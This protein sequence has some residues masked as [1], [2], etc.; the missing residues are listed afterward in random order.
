MNPLAGL[1]RCL[2]VR[3]VAAYTWIPAFA[4]RDNR[5]RKGTQ[6]S[7]IRRRISRRFDRFARRSRE[8]LV[9]MQ[10]DQFVA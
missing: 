6:R 4:V 3:L 7:R 2:N 10:L 5:Q 1:S 8:P 9:E